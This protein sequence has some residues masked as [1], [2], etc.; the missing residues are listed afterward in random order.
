MTLTSEALTVID[1][2]VPTFKVEGR[3][4][5]T[6]LTVDFMLNVAEIDGEMKSISEAVERNWFD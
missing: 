2:T 6:L 1:C 3:T 4:V 5:P